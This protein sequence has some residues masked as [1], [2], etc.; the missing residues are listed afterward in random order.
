MAKSTIDRI[1]QPVHNFIHREFTGGIVLFAS[2]VMAIVWVNSGHADSYHRFWSTELE[3]GIADHVFHASLHSWINDGLMALFFFVIGLELKREFMAGELSTLKKAMLPMIAALGGMI[4]PALIY[5]ACNYGKNS[6]DGWGIPMATD[7]AFALALLSIAGK[8]IPSSIKV[9][10]CALAVADDLGA[11][12][13]IALFYTTHIVWMPLLIAFFLWLLL[14]LGNYLGVRAPVFYLVIGIVFWGCFLVSGVHATI[15]GVLVALTIPARPKINEDDFVDSL[16]LH[17]DDFEKAGRLDGALITSEQFDILDRVKQLSLDAETPLQ[18]IE[19]A[20]HPWVAFVIMPAFALANAG[21]TLEHDFFTS[22]ANP[23]SLGI[24][25]GLIVGKCVGVFG[26]AWMLI[27]TRLA[28][29]PSGANWWQMWGVAV[30]AGVGF[31]MSLFITELAFKN[32]AQLIDQSKYG[33]LLASA[34]SAAVGILILKKSPNVNKKKQSNKLL[35]Q[36]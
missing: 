22:L 7:I 14:A 15:A 23:V 5:A 13:V 18:K 36:I 2:V 3:I 6:A 29:L 30:L 28:V 33:I 24:M 21:M 11:V 26:F 12:I 4:V 34:V 20:L 35:K 16:R 1:L 27:R 10:L 32:N 19:N 17:A 31:T 9:F 25:T 8:N